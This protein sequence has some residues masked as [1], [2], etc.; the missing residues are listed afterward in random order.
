M[1]I[2]KCVRTMPRPNLP[3]RF[4]K[5]R[6]CSTMIM[7]SWKCL[8]VCWSFRGKTIVS[9]KIYVNN[10]I[11]LFLVVCWLHHYS[12][13]SR[14]KFKDRLEFVFYCVDQN[15]D[16]MSQEIMQ[17]KFFFGKIV[18]LTIK[19]DEAARKNSWKN[20]LIKGLLVFVCASDWLN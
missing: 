5:K 17:H 16:V 15:S 18:C 19:Y 2:R 7:F 3:G 1:I 6:V 9:V 20:A 13:V 12:V 8:D 14:C 4:W 11:C 10:V